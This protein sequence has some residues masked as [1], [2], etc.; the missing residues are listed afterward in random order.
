MLVYLRYFLSVNHT[1][2]IFLCSLPEIELHCYYVLQYCCIA[3]HAQMATTHLE[4]A[5]D[6]P[7]LKNYSVEKERGSSAVL[8]WADTEV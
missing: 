1:Q 5:E 4:V 8:M 3:I 7:Q 2:P 6:P